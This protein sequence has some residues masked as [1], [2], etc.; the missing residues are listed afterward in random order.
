M[1]PPELAQR[2]AEALEQALHNLPT[3]GSCDPSRF[4]EIPGHTMTAEEVG[5]LKCI[6]L[7]EKR[8][9]ELAGEGTFPGAYRQGRSWMFPPESVRRYLQRLQRETAEDCDFD[10]EFDTDDRDDGAQVVRHIVTTE[11]PGNGGHPGRAPAFPDDAWDP[12]DDMAFNAYEEEF[13][14]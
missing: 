5:D 7:S 6:R 1:N 8:V 10:H 12:N 3:A 4:A 9:R 2:M 14:G 13:D 11:H